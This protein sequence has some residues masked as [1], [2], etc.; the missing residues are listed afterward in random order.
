MTASGERSPKHARRIEQWSYRCFLGA[1]FAITFSIALGE[2]LLVAGFILF[3]LFLFRERGFPVFPRVGWIALVFVIIAIFT[4][5]FGVNP[6]RGIHRL[7]RLFWLVALPMSATLIRSR[8]RLTEVFRAFAL[9]CGV[10]VF[11]V[12][13]QKPIQALLEVR[14]GETEGLDF[15][16]ALIDK[17]S[18]TDGQ[19][20]MMGVLVTA[21][22]I[23]I[24]RASHGHAV[25]WWLLLVVQT[26][27]V[28]VNFK[29][30][31]WICAGVFATVFVA[32]R[33]SWKSIIPVAGLILL[34]VALPV[35]R[36]RLSSLTD[37]LS[38]RSGGRMTM[39]VKI[40]PGLIRDHPWGVGYGSLTNEMMRKYAPEVEPD[41]G[42][43][44]SNVLQVLVETGW[45][46]FVVYMVWMI[47]AVV[48]GARSLKYS[49]HKVLKDE[50]L[51]VTVLLT[52]LAL[53]SNGLV[54][55]NFGD[56]E[57]LI[58]YAVL[59]GITGRGAASR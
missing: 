5:L 23:S 50:I 59:M 33:R 40:A 58:V 42:H 41:R 21:G 2:T 51:S 56:T 48:D 44:H 14:A 36:Y 12:C 15:L 52:L 47:H 26:V 30:G 49:R 17:G 39:W 18:M 22:L 19:M 4:A 6:P 55:Y 53:L 7:S 32:A 29:R 24:S 10:L 25:G 16:T 11:E 27:A 37:E 57:L 13:V 43:L 8:E 28:V 46:G 38:V 1:V 31:S 3:V 54:E 20:L 45:A 35:V 34:V 9:G